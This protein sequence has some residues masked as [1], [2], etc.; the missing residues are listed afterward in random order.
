VTQNKMKLRGDKK[1]TT[2]AKPIGDCFFPFPDTTASP[3]QR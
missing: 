2:A 3:N 1:G